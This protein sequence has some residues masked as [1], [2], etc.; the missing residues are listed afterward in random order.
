[1]NMKSARLLALDAFYLCDATNLC[2]YVIMLF[3][4]IVGLCYKNLSSCYS[5]VTLQ[6]YVDMISMFLCWYVY[7]Y[8]VLGTLSRLY[9]LVK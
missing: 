9:V 7:S 8:S 2:E 1:M 6:V 5:E 4:K 3:K